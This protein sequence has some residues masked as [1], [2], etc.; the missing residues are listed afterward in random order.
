MVMV[1]I[2]V[3]IVV[4]MVGGNGSD[5]DDGC[6]ANGDHYGDDGDGK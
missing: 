4:L 1:R 5:G 6:G 3:V 2:G